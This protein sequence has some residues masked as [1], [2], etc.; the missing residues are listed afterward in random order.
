[1]HIT[2]RIRL[3]AWIAVTVVALALGRPVYVQA[4]DQ[5]PAVALPTAP[6]ASKAATDGPPSASLASLP[7]DNGSPVEPYL[8]LFILAG[9]GLIAVVAVRVADAVVRKGGMRRAA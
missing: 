8:F 6:G 2:R 3:S 9:G 1:M 7:G 5:Q 4:Q